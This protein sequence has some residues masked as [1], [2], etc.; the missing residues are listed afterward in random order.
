MLAYGNAEATTKAVFSATNYL[1]ICYL[2]I[3]WTKASTSECSLDFKYS[4]PSKVYLLWS[5]RYEFLYCS[6]TMEMTDRTLA[7]KQS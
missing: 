5:T 3:E 7:N 4:F 6:L 1:A 2:E